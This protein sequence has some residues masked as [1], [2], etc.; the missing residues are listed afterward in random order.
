MP[1]CGEHHRQ[2]GGIKKSA[3]N[4]PALLRNTHVNIRKIS[5]TIQKGKKRARGEREKL[6]VTRCEYAVRY[7]LA[8]I[9]PYACSS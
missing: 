3:E 1:E 8:R 9:R 4:N 6:T 5:A 7:T 2:E